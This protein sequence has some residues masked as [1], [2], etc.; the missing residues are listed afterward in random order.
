MS[1]HPAEEQKASAAKA[2]KK[3]ANP[4]FDTIRPGL[5][6]DGPDPK[7][8]ARVWRENC[9]KNPHL[10]ITAIYEAELGLRGPGMAC[11]GC[12]TKII[13]TTGA[14]AIRIKAGTYGGGWDKPSSALCDAC[15]WI[16]RPSGA[17]ERLH[18]DVSE[19]LEFMAKHCGGSKPP[20]LAYDVA[21]HG[22]V[23]AMDLDTV[24][25]TQRVLPPEH[26]CSAELCRALAITEPL[27]VLKA[28][29]DLPFV[30]VPTNPQG[31]VLK[32]WHGMPLN[33]T[34]RGRLD[35]A[36]REVRRRGEVEIER[37][38]AQFRADLAQRQRA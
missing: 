37:E 17:I 7:V 33:G 1:K 27:D 29:P 35:A 13:T 31:H 23:V 4:P 9:D 12:D 38:V 24:K 22:D 21:R 26:D 3:P 18:D 5:T 2:A 32:E 34:E 19:Q 15:G 30:K 20:E 25:A 8:T 14:L 36:R 11:P 16:E 10:P 28:A 6:R